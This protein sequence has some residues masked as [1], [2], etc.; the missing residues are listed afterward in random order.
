[1]SCVTGGP[2]SGR[3]HSAVPD[4]P[5]LTRRVG[6][7]WRALG[8]VGGRW[9]ALGPVGRRWRAAGGGAIW[10]LDRRRMG[11]GRV[12]TRWRVRWGAVGS[13]VGVGLRKTVGA[14]ERWT[15]EDR[16]RP[17]P[18]PLPLSS[19]LLSSSPSPSSLSLPS[20]R[21]SRASG[22]GEFFGPLALPVGRWEPNRERWRVR[23]RPDWGRWRALAPDHVTRALGRWT[24][25]EPRAVAPGVLGLSWAWV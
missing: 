19:S 11:I 7:R 24:P 5:Q 8:P 10:L 15:T 1:V 9:R 22:A 2:G 3:R 13:G 20:R 25:L 14:L 4:S 17:R 23:W 12:P 18:V 21:R 6:G 16:W